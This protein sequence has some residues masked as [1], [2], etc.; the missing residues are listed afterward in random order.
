MALGVALR[1]IQAGSLFH[2]PALRGTFLTERSL[3][4]RAPYFLRGLLV[5]IQR[6]R[7][8]NPHDCPRAHHPPPP[9][10]HSCY[11]LKLRQAIS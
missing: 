10:D 2:S 3:S 4:E 1:Y 8:S 6:G 5:N 9:G 7:A 11:M